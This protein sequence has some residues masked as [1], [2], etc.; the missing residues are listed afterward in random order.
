MSRLA[1]EENFEALKEKVSETLKGIFPIEGKNQSLRLDDVLINDDKDIDDFRTQ[2]EARLNGRTWSVPVSASFSLIDNET[3]KVI[4]TRRQ[5]IMNLP[6]ITS[7][8]SYI[9][10]GQEYQVDNQWRLKYGVYSRKN[11]KGEIESTFHT[12]GAPGFKLRFDPESSNFVMKK[13][14]SEFPAYPILREMGVSDSNIEQIWGKEILETNRSTDPKKALMSFH[15]AIT[16]T[17][18]QNVEEAREYIKDYMAK[19]DMDEDV[20]RITLGRKQSVVDGNLMLEASGKLLGISRGTKKPDVRDSLIFKSFHSTEDFISEALTNRSR[21][22]LKKIRNNLDRKQQVKEIIGTDLFNKPIAHAFTKTSLSNHVDQTNPLEMLSGAMKTTIMGEGGIKDAHKITDDA[23][24]VD[25]SHLGFLDPIHTPESD[26]SGITLHLPVGAYKKGNTVVNK[27]YNLKTGKME[28]VDPEKAYNSKIALPDQVKWVKGKPVALHDEVKMSGQENEIITGS[29]KDADYAVTSPVQLF[30]IASNMVPF[31]QNNSGNRATY[32][33]KQMEQALSLKHREEPLVQTAIVSGRPES[34]LNEFVGRINSQRSPINGE[35]VEVKNDAIIVKGE[36]GKN[37]EV[38]I[39]D[40]FPL[41]DDKSFMH[42]DP[43]VKV[44]DKVKKGQTLADTNFSKNGKLAIGTN[45][46]AAYI[47]FKGYNFEDGI[48]ISESAAKKLT[49][50]HMKRKSLDVTSEHIQDKNKFIAYERANINQEQ[51]DKLSDDGIIKKGSLVMPGDTLIAALKKREETDEARIK[52]KMHKSLVKPYDNVSVKWESDYPGVVTGIVKKGGKTEVHV[53]TEEPA[54]IG[55]KLCGRSGNKG[56]ITRII[57][58]HE[59]PKTKDGEHVEIA[60]NPTGV[61]GRINLGQILETAAGKIAQKTGKPYTVQN[62]DGTEDM[63]ERVSRELKAHGIEDKEELVDPKTGKVMGKALVG[64]HYIHKLK[65]QVEKKLVARAGGPGYLYD[66]NKIPKSGSRPGLGAQAMDALGMYAMLAHG[67]NANVR[68]MAT[69][70]SDAENNDRL[71]SSIQAG[72]VLPPPRPSFA[73]NKFID[74]LKVAGVNTVKEGNSLNLV[75]ITDKQILEMSNGEIKDA[76]RI[77]TAKDIKEEKGGLLD[78][79]I[80]GGVSGTKWSHITL[81][82]KMP[83][84]IFEKSIVSL[85]GIKAK[86][87]E[88]IVY[89]RKAINT[90]TGKIVPPEDGISG[91]PAIEHLLS[92]VDVGKELEAAE[93]QLNDPNMRAD[94]LDPINKKVKYLKSLKRLDMNPVEAYMTKHVPVLPPSMR[95]ISV[96]Q[97]GTLIQDDMNGVYKG[98]GLVVNKFKDADPSVL[99]QED[100]NNRRGSIYDALK[101][102]SG[103]GGYINREHKGVLDI[104][105]GKSASKDSDLKSGSPRDS[106]F[107]SKLIKRKQDLSMRSTIIPEPELSLD[108]VGIP[109]QAA[110]EIYKPFVMKE[111]RG[112]TGV[113]PLQAQKLVEKGDTLANRAL[114]RVVENRPLLMKRDPVLHKYGVQAFKP[115]L[116]SGKAIKIH[117]LVTSGFNADF[118]GDQQINTVFALVPRDMYNHDSGFWG[119]RKV[120]MSARFKETVGYLESMDGEFAVCNLEDFPREKKLKSKDH[121]DFWTVPNGIKV[122]AMDERTNQ[123]VLADVS[124]WS[125]HRKRKVQIVEL[126]S[127]RQIITDDDERA[128]YGIDVSSLKWCRKR[129]DESKNQFV[130]VLSKIPVPDELITRIPLPDSPRLRKEARLDG[131]F[132]YFLGTMIG[133]GWPGIS[134]G[135]PRDVCFSTEYDSVYD[136]WFE[137]L[138]SVFKKHPNIYYRSTTRGQFKGSEGSESQIVSCAPLAVLIKELIGSGAENKHLPPFYISAPNIFI[139]G[140]LAGLWDTDGSVSWSE[141]KRTPQFMCSYTSKSIRLVQEIQ[142]LLRMLEISSTITSTVTPAGEPFWVLNVSIVDFH[143]FGGFS[144]KNRRKKEIQDEFLRE[145]QPDSS[146]S[147]SRYRL[148]PVPSALANE[149]RTVLGSSCRTLYVTL[150]KAIER[151]YVSKETAVRIIKIVG[152]RCRHP[153]YSEWKSIVLM[154]NVHF[155]RV[156]GVKKTEI[157]EDGYDLTVPGYETF[158]SLDGVI[159]SNTMSAFVPISSEAVSEAAKMFP[160]RNLFNPATGSLMYKPTLESQ[161]GL[162]MMSKDGDI[163]DKSFKTFQEAADAAKK[164]QIAFTD[165]VKIGKDKTTVGKMMIANSLPEEMRREII[166]GGEMTGKRQAEILT[167]VA[168]ERKADFGQVADKFKD[169]GNT[170]SSETAFSL[171]IED[172]KTDKSRRNRILEEADRRV[173]QALKSKDPNKALKDVVSVYDKASEKMIETIE[174]EHG[175]KPTNL[176]NMMKSGIKPQMEAYRQITMAPMLVMNAKGEVIPN[177]IRKSWSEGLDTGDYWTQMSGARKGVIQKVQSVKDPGYFTKQVVN[178]VMNNSILAEDCGTKR[179]ISLDVSEK[180]ILDRYLSEDIKVGN[181]VLKKDTLITPGVRDTL[182]NNK[183]NKVLVRSPLRCEHGRGLCSRCYGLDENGE[184][185]TTGKNV[186]IVSAQSIGERA[187]QLSMKTFHSGGVAPVGEKSKQQA[188]LTDGFN[189][190]QQLVQMNKTVPGSATLSTVNGVVDSVSKDK[191]GGY[192]V[193][194]SGVRHYIP[195]DRGEP[196]VFSGNKAVP[197]TKGSKIQKGAPLSGGPINPHEMLPLTGINKVQSYVSGALHDLYKSEGIRRRNIETAVKS[198]TNLTK[199][200][201]PGDNPEFIRGDFAPTSYVQALNKQL[202]KDKRKPIEHTPVIKGVKT[203]PLDIQ[204]DWMA[205]LNHERLTDTVIDA[206]NQGWKSDIHGTHPIPALVYGAEFGKGKPY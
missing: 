204:T 171:G 131:Q 51:A 148:V 196:M 43:I 28:E 13:G 23:K 29:L 153:L 84:P 61:A 111:I 33:G 65:H 138:L 162:Y 161:L 146:M 36:D 46:K 149:L 168:K 176:F 68:E 96:M 69:Y 42:S 86:E 44:G 140:L 93:K 57:P 191:A 150:S 139:K 113:S 8:H 82:E 186:G 38:Q 125:F 75:P 147:Y 164:G 110:M 195:Q 179:G 81:P 132:G 105:S 202:V 10:D 206:A 134:K 5:K 129:P 7:R 79:Q 74:L 135:V 154:N 53:R 37:R 174:K 160:S 130:P 34:S 127:G 89:G 25:E 101:S 180:D 26:R 90:K 194:I 52:A 103:L 9:V 31:L 136:A 88:D 58:D 94:K 145:K 85:T 200:R 203:M 2:K 104:I 170:Y 11:D 141:G 95:P 64:P 133:N 80:T 98:L 87:Y 106:Y 178:T 188:A 114:E 199:I 21:D 20:N 108:Q 66:M 49:S 47:P 99:P 198:M 183:V 115:I 163:K 56:I 123:P 72:D 124:G 62:F 48:V 205:R 158:M 167:R 76:G 63:T 175:K 19:T 100:I 192:S 121:I 6:K 173:K 60:L 201:N 155:E 67:A 92:K 187:T 41:N 112:M 91:G 83:N 55:D 54:E 181:K 22:I 14:N 193:V 142:Q 71:W 166:T 116:T 184:N 32:A 169:M 40:N 107:Q 143:R 4:N 35:I 97:D 12:R 45:L 144:L 185:V 109:R 50:E 182:R 1:P 24:L 172:L 152:E 159:L 190:V 30:S 17:K 77:V 18:A 120:G 122:V 128:V 157:R 177:P 197:I 59:M 70:K 137:S 151:Q 73:Y 3:G 102:V 78:K 119:A 16:G 189:R 126:G 27:L 117:P 156:K 165:V 118:D 39:Y 15:R